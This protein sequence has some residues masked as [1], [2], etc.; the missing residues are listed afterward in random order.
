MPGAASPAVPAD[1]IPSTLARTRASAQP[2]APRASMV[3]AAAKRP[4]RRP[5]RRRGRGAWPAAS[6]CTTLVAVDFLAAMYSGAIQTPPVPLC[7]RP[8]TLT[9]R[10][11][12]QKVLRGQPGEVAEG[13]AAWKLFQ[14]E[15]RIIGYCLLG[16]AK[17]NNLRTRCLY[18]RAVEIRMP[19]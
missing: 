10:P 9:Q 4:E 16:L 15:L 17:S 12:S 3:F 11:R 1:G 13:A 18:L 14:A 8:T 6:K 5:R 19:G 2:V 7:P